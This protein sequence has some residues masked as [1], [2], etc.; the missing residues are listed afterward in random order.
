MPKKMHQKCWCII[1]MKTIEFCSTEHSNWGGIWWWLPVLRMW[2]NNYW[3]QMDTNCCALFT[4][5]HVSHFCWN[6]KFK[7]TKFWWTRRVLCRSNR[8]D[9]PRTISGSAIQI[10]CIFTQKI[11]WQSQIFDS[12]T[13][14]WN[15]GPGARTKK[16]EKK[17]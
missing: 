14:G 5:R 10:W 16:L 15:T 13:V 7:G 8:L 11:D 3:R 9:N 1:I 17:C 12:S 6:R 2:W 4:R